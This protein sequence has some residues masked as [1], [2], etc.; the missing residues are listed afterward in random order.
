MIAVRAVVLAWLVWLGAPAVG[1]AA[2]AGAIVRSALIEA[3][4]LRCRFAQTKHLQGFRHPLVSAGTVLYSRDRGVVW[5][6]TEPFA[7]TVVLTRT[8]VLTRSGDGTTHIAV[9]GDA[10]PSVVTGNELMLALLGG[11][12]D[13]LAKRFTIAESLAEDGSWR[14]Q[15]RPKSGPLSQLFERIDLHGDRYLRGVSLAEVGGDRTEIRFLAPYDTS[16]PLTAAEVKQ[17]E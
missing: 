10:S 9:G 1:E 2:T 11:D 7:S 17:F 12:I 6:T 5:N 13:I 16:A 8:R 14:L 4:V 3:P 15:L